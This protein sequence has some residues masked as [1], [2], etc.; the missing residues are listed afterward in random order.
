MEMVLRQ[1]PVVERL[2]LAEMQGASFAFVGIPMPRL[3][4]R[5]QTLDQEGTTLSQNGTSPHDRQD[6]RLVV[7]DWGG[8]H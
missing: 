3:A 8:R 7:E 2:G 4:R 1:G 5:I 6:R